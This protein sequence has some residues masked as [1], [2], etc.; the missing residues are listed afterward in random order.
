MHSDILRCFLK[1]LCH[2]C[3][4]QPHGVILQTDIYLCLSI[5]G[6]IYNDFVFFHIV[7]CSS[8]RSCAFAIVFYVILSFLAYKVITFFEKLF[9]FC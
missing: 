2:L 6:L 7:L 3:L 9:L 5:L 8:A 1:Q 4:R